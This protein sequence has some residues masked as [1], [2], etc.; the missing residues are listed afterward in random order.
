M[1]VARGSIY[2]AL[3]AD[4]RF[5]AVLGVYTA[6]VTLWSTTEDA[7]P[8]RKKWTL[9][10]LLMLPAVDFVMVTYAKGI[11]QQSLLFF[12]VPVVCRMMVLALMPKKKVADS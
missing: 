7:H 2:Y 10:F 9:I 8:E 11:M 6:L 12:V 4:W 5:A 3:V 1:A